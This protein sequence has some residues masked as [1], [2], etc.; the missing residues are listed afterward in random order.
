MTRWRWLLPAG[1]AA[2]IVAWVTALG[3]LALVSDGSRR[4]DEWQ[5]WILLVNAI[6]VVALITLIGRQLAG[7]V[8]DWRQH[9]P[10]SRLRGRTMLMFTGLAVA[11]LL[12]VF[13][14][15]VLF[16]TRG[17]DSWFHAEVRQGLSDAL[18][19][20][21]AALD[22]RMREVTERTTRIAD[23]LDEMRG[24]PLV[25]A[26]D[27]H[28]RLS[29]AEELIVAAPGGQPEAYST[30]SL[31]HGLPA[32]AG[33]ELLLQVRQGRPYVS[34]E[35]ASD[36]YLIRVAT[37]LGSGAGRPGPRLLIATYPVPQR[38]AE[39]AET[40]QGAYQEYGRLSFLRE[41]LKVSFVLTLSLVL[42]LA[43]LA[44]LYGALYF[45]QRLVRP[46]QDLIAGTRAV[47]K[48]DF[49]TRLARASHD[50]VGYLVTSFN[51]MT[52]RLARAREEAQR[53]RAAVEDERAALAAVLARLTSGVI[54][55]EPDL[56]VRVA[57]AAAGQI[58]GVDFS[59]VAGRPLAELASGHPVLAQLLDFVQAQLQAGGGDWREQLTLR[60][61]SSR[62]ELVCACATLPGSGA[63]GGGYVLVFDEIT[64]LLQAQ[65]EA[66]WGEVARRL[67]HEIRNPL[68]PIQLSAERLRRKLHDGLT[69]PQA[70]LLDRATHTIVQQVEA[71][72]QMVAA[73]SEY[74]RAPQ[75]Q[76]AE[77]D[78]AAMIRQVTDLFHAQDPRVAFGLRLDR[79]AA[80]LAADR[81]R[82]R[83][84]LNNL[85]TN[86]LEALDG[87]ADPFIMIETRRTGDQI[88][89][90]VTDNGP[91]FQPGLAAQAFDPYVTSKAKGTGLGLAIVRRIV[92]E[93][94]GHVE[95][96]NAPGG[97]A[98]I[99]VFLPAVARDARAGEA[100]REQA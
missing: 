36:G 99:T 100:R 58:L 81:G 91:G 94:G 61:E 48:G 56:R 4:F 62:R 47:A 65:R 17:I 18:G 34:L 70:E 38:L 79:E 75:M 40:V 80:T 46:V 7:F 22:L 16:L 6:G 76:I 19:L 12:V 77:F 97:G 50:E 73:F 85:L 60:G 13:T 92:E 41:P 5:P 72:K 82:I 87:R 44:A 59:G 95:L 9:I 51:D 88:L 37:A 96:A 32:V 55:L 54:S 49:D 11:P 67:A 89:L 27:G 74:A 90:T 83:Q 53:S 66:A 52:V 23:E 42:L 26:L 29:G 64:A 25:A 63:A 21:R 78:L 15:S 43:L 35:P 45:S 98:R 2:G 39:L 20:S 31:Q 68:T 30:A 93:H 10:G 57:N 8:A 1:V 3:L 84:L 14:F 24:L 71:M 69:P 33:E 28:R 86:A